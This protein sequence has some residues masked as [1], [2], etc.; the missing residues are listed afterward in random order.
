MRLVPGTPSLGG[1]P[2]E[3]A[4]SAVPAPTAPAV[5]PAGA[6]ISPSARICCI[7]FCS[8]SGVGVPSFFCRQQRSSGGVCGSGSR[9]WQMAAERGLHFGAAA[10]DACRLAH[11]QRPT[12]CQA[13]T[14]SS[15]SGGGG[16]GGGGRTHLLALRGGPSGILALRR[17]L[18]RKLLLQLSL[19]SVLV[20]Q[21]LCSCVV[22]HRH[23]RRRGTGRQQV[24]QW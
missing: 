22:Q 17:L 20:T 18:R 12:A 21:I 24:E 15:N 11:Q 14:P 2:P 6:A 13:G 3:P 8:S 5:P 1:G 16:C 7:I 9:G 10:M 4:G 23:L 19:Q